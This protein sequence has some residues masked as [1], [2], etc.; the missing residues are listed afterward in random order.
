MTIR[1]SF[2]LVFGFFLA[3]SLPGIISCGDAPPPEKAS[4]P[5]VDQ[6]AQAPPKVIKRIQDPRVTKDLEISGLE[7]GQYSWPP[8]PEEQEVVDLSKEPFA[9]NYYVVLDGSGSMHEKDC[10]ENFRSKMDAAKKALAD[11]VG[12]VPAEANIGLM[13]FGGDRYLEQFPLRENNSGNKNMFYKKIGE[14]PVGGGT[15]IHNAMVLGLRAIEKQAQK[16]L[17]YGEYN[18]VI[19]TDGEYNIGP[20]PRGVV[21][22]IIKNTPIK[23]HTIGFCIR[24]GHSLNQPDK[25]YYK[26]ATNP[27]ELKEGLESVLAESEKFVDLDKFNQ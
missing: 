23:I 16:Q 6:P 8:V 10:A 13:S 9:K 27:A 20:D 21:N 17:G 18:L 5:A 11:F 22:F 1:Q 19:I 15:P 3:L 14:I 25:I 2:R 7:A 24:S 26:T 4:P 12:L